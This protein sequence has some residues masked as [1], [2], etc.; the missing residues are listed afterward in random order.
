MADSALSPAIGGELA[1]WDLA[2]WNVRRA[3]L[4]SL[5]T[6][7]TLD[8]PGH[9]AVVRDDPRTETTIPLGVIGSNNNPIQNEEQAEL[10]MQILGLDRL[11]L[12]DAGYLRDGNQVFLV[13]EVPAG[14]V[15]DSTELGA[16]PTRGVFELLTLNHHDGSG[17][18]WFYVLPIGTWTSTLRPLFDPVSVRQPGTAHVRQHALTRASLKHHASRRGIAGKLRRDLRLSLAH[19]AAIEAL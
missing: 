10:L 3:P 5:D 7:G 4:V 9:S 15:V 1:R 11:D 16:S 17:A 6:S 19:S 13:C 2:D 8:V 18:L 12:L 14:F